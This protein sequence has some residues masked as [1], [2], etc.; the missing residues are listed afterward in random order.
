MKHNALT[1]IDALGCDRHSA[2]YSMTVQLLQ[3]HNCGSTKSSVHGIEVDAAGGGG[4]R[5]VV[6]MLLRSPVM[7]TL[8]GCEQLSGCWSAMSC[9]KR[10]TIS[11]HE[12]SMKRVQHTLVTS[13]D[14]TV[15]LLRL[16]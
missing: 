6:L 1:Q 7:S 4:W 12:C 5:L 8:G 10:S 13:K 14:K 3:Q 16:S 15:D 11:V 9:S 2:G